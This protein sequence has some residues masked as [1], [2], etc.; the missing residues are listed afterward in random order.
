MAQRNG[1]VKLARLRELME[2]V[3]VGGIKQKGI[4]ALIINSDDAHQSEYLREQ[5]KR[6]RFIS[7]FTGSYG[8]AI[9]TPNKALL[10]TDGRYYV[11]ALAEFDRSSRSMDTY[12]RRF[13]RNSNEGCMVGF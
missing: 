11:Q 1:T 4:Q 8:T 5:D 12:E 10:W 2:A 13:I 3:Q 9:I 6:V 7:G